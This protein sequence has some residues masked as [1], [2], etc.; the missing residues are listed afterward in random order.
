MKR[1]LTLLG[2]LAALLIVPARAQVPEEYAR[3]REEAGEASVLFRGRQATKYTMAYNGN[4]Y[5]DSPEF[6]VGTVTY[7]EKAYEGILLNID[8]REQ[9]VLV[10]AAPNLPSIV[11]S[12]DE[13]PE[14]TI[15]G[16]RWI[17]PQAMGYNA[18]EGFFEVLADR[19]SVLALRRVGKRL[20]QS[21]D[22]K[23]GK[24]IGY[25]DPDYRM[26]VIDYFAFSESFYLLQDGKCAKAGR[27]K[28]MR[29]VN[30]GR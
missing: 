25:T 14:F 29:Y 16:V 5:W 18:P 27:R 1:K 12:R 10:K 11:L 23:N 26:N 4:P 17:N 21:A 2:C 22:N 3:F 30:E 6:H 7:N 15:D 8:A 28:V 9:Q 13:V 19:G 20:K 24:S